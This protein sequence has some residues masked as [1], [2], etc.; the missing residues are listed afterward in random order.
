MATK[1]KVAA[2]AP[3]P[4]PL[5]LQINGTH[6]KG[7]TIQPIEFAMANGLDACQHTIVKYVTRFREKNGIDDLLKAR[8]VIDILIEMETNGVTD[9]LRT[10]LSALT[11]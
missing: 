8:H 2:P 11:E 9:A 1:M 10:R 7:M 3:A 6:Y 5:D 4:N